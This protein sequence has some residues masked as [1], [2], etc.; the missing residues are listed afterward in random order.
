MEQLGSFGVSEGGSFHACEYFYSEADIL[1]ED[2]D[3]SDW[4]EL[5]NYGAAPI[6][7]KGW[8]LT[9]DPDDLSNRGTSL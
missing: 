1:D 9:D 5:W 7:L 2:G 3:S 4:I 6:D 8:H